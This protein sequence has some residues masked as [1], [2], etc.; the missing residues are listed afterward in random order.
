MFAQ[1]YADHALWVWLALGAAILAVEVAFGSGW[2]LWPAASAGV[3]GLLSGVLDTTAQ[4]IG[5]F[6]ALTIVSTLL[7]RRF[8][9][10]KAEEGAD[11]NDNVARLVGH[12]GKAAAPF[13][14]R[15]GRVL[16]DGKEWAAELDEGESL[17]AG[18]DVEVI[19]LSGGSRLRVR[20]AR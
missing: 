2:L 17:S 8:W 11:I 12:R 10:S 13:D 5:L 9:P 3:V 1:I 19:G 14:G 4:E 15:S 16:I 6:A 18:G 20:A 7:A